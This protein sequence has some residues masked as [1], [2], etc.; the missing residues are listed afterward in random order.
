M[1]QILRVVLG[2]MIAMVIVFCVFIALLIGNRTSMVSLGVVLGLLGVV[3][4]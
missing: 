2:E 4:G 1:S 3:F